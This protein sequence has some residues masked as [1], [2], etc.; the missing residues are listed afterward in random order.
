M[1]QKVLAFDIDGVIC[2]TEGSDYENSKPNKKAIEK[3]NHLYDEGN[4]III[5]TARYMG[6]NNN[7]ISKA[8]AEGYELTVKQLKNWNVKYHKLIMGKPSFD[9]IIDDKAYNYN[10]DWINEF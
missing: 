9:I 1:K 5:F 2:H 6:R 7:D 4:K 8:K 3:I 10:K